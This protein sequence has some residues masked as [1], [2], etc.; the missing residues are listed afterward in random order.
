MRYYNILDFK[1][2]ELYTFTVTAEFESITK[3]A[4]YLYL[5]PSQVSKIIRKLENQ[6]GVALFIRDKNGLRLTPAGKH[7]YKGLHSTLDSV[8][9]T[10]DEMMQIQAVKP[11]LRIACPTLAD[12][13]ELF[14][15]MLQR[16]LQ[17]QPN[18]E[19]TIECK[20]TLSALRKMLL[21]GE[22]DLI[23]TADFEVRESLDVIDW[24]E[25]ETVPLVA[26]V[27]A[28]NP[29]AQKDA[30]DISDLKNQQFVLTSPVSDAYNRFVVSQCQSNGFTPNVV[31][32]VPNIYSQMMEVNIN[33]SAVCVSI[34]RGLNSHQRVCCR[35]L[36]GLFWKMGFAFQKDAPSIVRQFIHTSID[37][38]PE[39]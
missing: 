8:R 16:F 4:N 29:I 15:P 5:T 25:V 22:V 6:W 3:A 21:A 20:D 34:E 24:Q 27:N 23:Y 37:L 10:L 13:N 9:K 32:Y 18:A 14:S 31:R 11:F 36:P 7:A 38:C 35:P 26:I 39:T 33:P 2:Q 12:P 28:R 1:L 17:V 19:I 30:I